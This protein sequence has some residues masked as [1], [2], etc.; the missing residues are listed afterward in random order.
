MPLPYSGAWR[1][2]QQPGGSL[3]SLG[4]EDEVNMALRQEFDLI[5]LGILLAETKVWSNRVGACAI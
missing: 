4:N 2:A 3:G 5:R 1:F